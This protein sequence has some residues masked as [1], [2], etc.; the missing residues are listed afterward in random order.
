MRIVIA[1]IVLALVGIATPTMSAGAH[2]ATGSLRTERL[3]K[4]GR[5]VKH[6]RVINVQH[7]KPDDRAAVVFNTGSVWLLEPC[8]YE[9]SNN[10]YWTARSRGNGKGR[11]FVTLKGKTYYR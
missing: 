6:V 8:G 9:D 1:G 4:P 10:C 7:H 2:H 11:S 3:V 5:L